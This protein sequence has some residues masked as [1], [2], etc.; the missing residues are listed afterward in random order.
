MSHLLA[1]TPFVRACHI[2]FLT[3]LSSSLP[4]QHHLEGRYYGKTV[5]T[6]QLKNPSLPEDSSAQYGDEME[7][8]IEP[9]HK[10][11]RILATLR[12]SVA[13]SEHN[14]STLRC[15]VALLRATIGEEKFTGLALLHIHKDI[16][17]DLFNND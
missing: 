17:I 3:S 5:L 10:R 1:S 4:Q 16:E 14:F 9:A 6:I 7:V 8:D 13:T 12:V 15:L 2:F 11:Q